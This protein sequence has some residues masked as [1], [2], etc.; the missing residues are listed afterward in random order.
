MGE[1][2]SELR[3]DP[4]HRPDRA[5]FAA[6]V[7]EKAVGGCGT[8]SINCGRAANAY[9]PHGCVSATIADYGGWPKGVGGLPG[10]RPSDDVYRWLTAASGT[11]AI[12]DLAGS[13]AIDLRPLELNDA[14]LDVV[15][16]DAS[17]D[18]SLKS[19][20]IVTDGTG[21]LLSVVVLGQFG[22][23]LDF[24]SGF[25]QQVQIQRVVLVDRT[26]PFSD[27]G[28]TRSAEATAGNR[29]L[30]QADAARQRQLGDEAPAL[31]VEAR[32]LV[33]SL[34]TPGEVPEP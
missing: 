3:G 11:V 9:S 20:Q 10:I 19:L 29:W 4:R 7:V 28:R 15:N 22:G 14:Y 32:R 2:Q 27:E 12:A 16:L 21:D 1:Q 31:A 6:T 26:P 5:S 33:R 34:P 18:G 17:A 8:T 25:G 13:D 23:Y 24:A 30:R